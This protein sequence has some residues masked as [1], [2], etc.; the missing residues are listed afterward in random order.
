MPILQYKTNCHLL[1]TDTDIPTGHHI[2]IFISL[3]DTTYLYLYP[4]WTP[5]IYIYIPTGHHIFIFI[6]LLDTTYLYLYP[7][8]TPHIYIYIP[9]GHHIYIYMI[10]LSGKLTLL[11]RILLKYF[12]ELKKMRVLSTGCRFLSI[13][14]M[15]INVTKGDLN[16]QPSNL[17]WTR[18]TFVPYVK[19]FLPIVSSM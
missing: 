12:L 7:Y 2:F 8:W 15:S 6:S 5:H 16:L 4:Y 1:L 9:T 11:F 19:P 18:S 3:L 17:K 10:K 14:N 13:S